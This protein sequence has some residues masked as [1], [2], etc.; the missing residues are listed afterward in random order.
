MK[1]RKPKHIYVNIILIHNFPIAPPHTHC[2]RR[3]QALLV[4]Q[5]PEH[6]ER[7]QMGGVEGGEGKGGGRISYTI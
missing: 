1:I 4:F 6:I 7:K 2:K 5:Y 3:L